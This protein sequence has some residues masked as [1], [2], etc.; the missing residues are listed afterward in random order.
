MNE[1]GFYKVQSV[2][3]TIKTM[4]QDLESDPELK[5]WRVHKVFVGRDCGE[6]TEFRISM[7]LKPELKTLGDY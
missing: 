5:E 6:I 2:E 3:K 1:K 7:G 4:L